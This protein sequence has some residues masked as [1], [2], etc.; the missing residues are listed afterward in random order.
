MHFNEIVYMGSPLEPFKSL[1]LFIPMSLTHLSNIAKGND[2]ADKFSWLS[3]DLIC[4]KLISPLS[5][6][7]C[8]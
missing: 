8:S 7:W 5:K 4:K 3:Q 6:G 1:S 2:L